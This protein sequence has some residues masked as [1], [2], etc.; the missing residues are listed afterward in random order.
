MVAMA[1][2]G[3]K[4]LLR[5][6]EVEQPRPCGGCNVLVNMGKLARRNGN[7][8]GSRRW[9]GVYVDFCFLARNALSLSTEG[10]STVHFL[11]WSHLSTLLNITHITAA[12]FHPQSNS[13]VER[14]HRW[15]KAT[16]KA[17]CSS[18]QWSTHLPWFLLS[19]CSS[20][21][22]LTKIISC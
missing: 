4:R 14:F 10:H 19:F 22:K 18:P 13:L 15:L 6:M 3:C 1:A 17:Y 2:S 21:P 16:L 8:N 5:W 7:G 9:I 11:C 20:L 12:A